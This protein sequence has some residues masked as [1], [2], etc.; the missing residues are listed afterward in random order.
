MKTEKRFSIKFALLAL[1]MLFSATVM[2]Q[3]EVTGV[4][5]DDFGPVLGATVREKGTQNGVAT[6]MDGKFKLKVKNANATLSISYVGYQTQDVNLA[7][8]TN[9]EVRMKPDAQMLE[10][11][12]V[13]GYGKMKRSDLA[14]ASST[15]DSK[16]LEEGNITNIDQAFQGRV[17]G[18]TSI[19]T[20]GAP[21]AS[22]SI[23][24]RGQATINADAE[25]LY[26]IDG[27]IFQSGGKSG[28]DLEIGRAH[29]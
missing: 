29:V 22:Q 9:V 5:N 23:R 2:A 7:G 8:R 15:L 11:T 25:P 1:C 14:G 6:D 27:V 10:E 19:A 18:V 17:A 24:V 21:G 13:V 4:V 20:S 28:A 26:V 12:V 16:A 3:V